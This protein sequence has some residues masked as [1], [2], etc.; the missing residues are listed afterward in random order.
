MVERFPEPHQP[1]KK[2]KQLVGWV[3]M[4]GNS[5][6]AR[7]LKSIIEDLGMQLIIVSEHA[8]ADIKWDLN[9]YLEVMTQFDILI[10][11]QNVNLQPAKSN[12]KVVTAMA[13]G[14]PLVCSPNP[15]YLEIV[16]H[17]EN[18]FIATTQDEWHYCLKQLKESIELRKK[19]SQN[20]LKTARNFSPLAIASH[21]KGLLSN[22]PTKVAFINNTLPQKYLSYGDHFLDGLRLTGYEVTEFRYEDIN[23]LPA[24]FDAYLFIEVRYNPEDIED[25]RFDPAQRISKPPR[26]LYTRENL[27]LNVLPNFDVVVSNNEELVQQW[28]NR[29]FINTLCQP[30]GFSFDEIYE[31]AK[32]DLIEKRKKHNFEIHSKHID[33]FHNLL[34]PEE[35]WTTPRDAEHIKFT[36]EYTKSGE[37]VLD[38]GSADGWL[39]IYLAKEGCEVSALEFVERGI[40]WTKKQ[41]TRFGVDIDLRHGFIEALPQVFSD[42]KFDCILA[43]E[44]LEHLD[45]LKLPWY[46]KL[47]ESML[48]KGGKILISLP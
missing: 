6:L 40:D 33:S 22:E 25:V 29:G 23:I 17:G 39:S 15:A 3:G 16:E 43:Y 18:G 30:S 20:G 34:L 10:C 47:M 31:F 4:G 2:D 19:F 45:Y 37:S 41:V 46:L 27:N 8:D 13:T 38:I 21:W 24:G 42:K 9:N 36:M 32:T 11:P 5:Y 26:I 28:Q 48:N 1:A 35:R 12:V 7:N 14:V 44:I